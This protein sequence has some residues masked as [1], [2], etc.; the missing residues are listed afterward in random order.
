MLFYEILREKNKN[1]TDTAKS[2]CIIFPHNLP[3]TPFSLRKIN[4]N[5]T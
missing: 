5:F 2:S 1:E 4:I 3:N